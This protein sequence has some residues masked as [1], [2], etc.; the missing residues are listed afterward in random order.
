MNYFDAPFVQDEMRRPFGF[1]FGRPGFGFGRP[2][3]G[4]GRPGFFGPPFLGGFAGGLLAG[5][6]LAPGYGY[7][8]PYPPPYGPYPY[9]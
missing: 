9:Y 3:F 4:Y 6:L 8:Y 7:G 5:S 1:G 2:G